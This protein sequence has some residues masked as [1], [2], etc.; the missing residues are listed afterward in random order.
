MLPEDSLKAALPTIKL[1]GDKRIQH[2]YDPEQRSGK[3]IAMSVG[4]PGHIAWDIYLFYI[5][6]IEWAEFPPKPV[7]WMH[8]VSDEWAKDEHYRTGDDLKYELTKSL[9]SLLVL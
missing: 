6:G 9:K 7:R 1:L 8:Q 3:E 4:W 2:F 5:P